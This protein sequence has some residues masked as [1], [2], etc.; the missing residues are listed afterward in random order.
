MQNFP[1][2]F[3]EISTR[4]KLFVGVVHLPFIVNIRKSRMNKTKQCMDLSEID[5]V[6]AHYVIIDFRAEF[7][8]RFKIR[9]ATQ[10]ARFPL[11]Q[12]LQSIVNRSELLRAVSC[13]RLVASLTL[14]FPSPLLAS[15]TMSFLS[16]FWDKKL[17]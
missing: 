10:V 5:M 7:L 9:R 13:E 6:N 8:I 11:S 12:S 4:V 3:G 14:T 15:H 17:L 2:E 16:R 1:L